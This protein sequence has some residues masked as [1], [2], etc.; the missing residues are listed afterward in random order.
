[1]LARLARL[2]RVR[3]IDAV[4]TV[5]AGDKMFWGRL[6]A[7]RAGV[8]VVVSALHAMGSADRVQWPNRLLA[9]L[10][11]A[12]IAVAEPQARY[13]AEHEGCPPRKVRVIP[14][15]VDVE[16]FRPLRP[17]PALRT[18]LGLHG[19]MP[20]VGI[21]AALRPEKNHELFLR[22]AV[23]I[24]RELP[25]TR[26]LII[27]DGPRRPALEAL[28]RELLPAAAIRFLGTRRDV[29]ELLALVNVM[30]LTSHEEASP[31]SILEAMAAGKPVV[32]TQVGS[33]GQTV[34]EGRTGYLVPPGSAGELARRTVELLRDP[35]RASGLGR[36]GRRYV[37]EHW[38]IAGTVEGYQGLVAEIYA[39]KVARR[40]ASHFRPSPA[41]PTAAGLGVR[42]PARYD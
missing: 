21:L 34:L 15:G 32:A 40:A 19:E 33:V 4:V 18:E 24:G 11:D 42:P 29:P 20:V 39:A 28:A 38:S 31:V 5:G 25:E 16:R 41:P 7:R 23:A 2:M 1:V 36:A 17:S 9:P 35:A 30:L 26:F 14:N 10:T 37:V 22:A 3:R 8:P 12:F 6:A 27:G 13:L